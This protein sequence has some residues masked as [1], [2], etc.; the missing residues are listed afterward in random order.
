[1]T[2]A[3]SNLT[4]GGS[5]T[6]ATSFTTASVTPSANA[7]VLCAVENSVSGTPA[8]PTLSGNGLTWVQIATCHYDQSG[9][10]YRVTLFAPWVRVRAAVPSPSIWVG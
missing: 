2:I 6:D 3:S 1:M 4:V 7:L 8:T 9:T 10:Q 5:G